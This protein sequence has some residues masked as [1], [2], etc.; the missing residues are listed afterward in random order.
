MNNR[1]LLRTLLAGTALTVAMAAP[2]LTQ[3]LNVDLA[4]LDGKSAECRALGQFIADQNGSIAGVEPTRVADAVN[5]DVAAECAQIQQ[6]LVAEAGTAP[7]AAQTTADTTADTAADATAE[8]AAEA[9]VTT[10]TVATA[11]EATIVGEAIVRV[12]EPNVDVRVPQP[13]VTVRTVAPQVSVQDGAAQIEVRQAQPE[14]AVEI[15]TINVRVTMPAPRIYVLQADPQ[16]SVAAADPQVEVVQGEPE[17]T[18]TQPDPELEIDLGIAGGDQVA[19]DAMQEVQEGTDTASAQ[20]VGGNVEL[21]QAQ[22][23][24]SFV[25]SQEQPQVEITRAQPEVSFTGAQPNVIITLAEQ[26][27]VDVQMTGEPQVV[28]ETPEERDQRRASEPQDGADAAAA[29][30]AQI[31]AADGA[32]DG[33]AGTAPAG[34]MTVGDLRSL[35]VVTADGEDLGAPEAVIEMEGQQYLLLSS[36]GFMGIGDKVVPVPMASVSVSENRLMLGTVTEADVERARDFDYD[37]NAALS[38]DQPVTMAN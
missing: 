27:T 1:A 13:E 21:T 28:I 26:P 2:G 17:I 3:T 5:N 19:A 20:P 35:S 14:I 9:E 34:A 25:A 18:I 6:L 30:A 11:Q 4:E 33:T 38:D 12:P 16:V 7:D 15:P 23:I 8:A 10:E 31:L 37:A 32:A 29:G 36:G 22:P 24:V